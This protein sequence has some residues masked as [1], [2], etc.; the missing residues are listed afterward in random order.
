MH[1]SYFEKKSFEVFT[2]ADGLEG[3]KL[4]ETEQGNFD[5]IIT[6]IVMPAVSGIGIITIL[7]DRYPHV[8]VVA[9]TGMGQ[10]PETLATAGQS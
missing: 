4:L 1:K 6:D 7:K 9:I 3:L 8:P 2:A 10:Q 5:V